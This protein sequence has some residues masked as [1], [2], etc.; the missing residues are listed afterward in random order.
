MVGGCVKLVLFAASDVS[1]GTEL[2]YDY[3][4]SKLWWRKKVIQLRGLCASAE[5]SNS[6]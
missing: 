6:F 3:G 4:D 1:E 5:K 2:R